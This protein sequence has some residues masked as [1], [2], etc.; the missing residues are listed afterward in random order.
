MDEGS[1]GREPVPGSERGFGLV[2]GTVLLL[3]AA[4]G[5]WL[6]DPGVWQPL[7][8]S[9]GAALVVLGMVRP[10]SLGA[11]NRAWFRF[12]MLLGRIVAPVVMGAIFLLTVVPT[13]LLLRLLRRDPLR[14][15][16]RGEQSYWILR[17]DTT[18]FREQF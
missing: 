8:A 14:R 9:V 1:Y 11:L 2:V 6:H 16:D 13:G 5:W 7:V 15:R 10:R 3:I 17:T 4:R 18:T 12:G